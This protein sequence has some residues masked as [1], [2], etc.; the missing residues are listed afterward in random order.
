[1]PWPTLGIIGARYRWLLV[2]PC[3]TPT[4]LQKALVALAV[5]ATFAV[6]YFAHAEKLGKL[7]YYGVIPALLFNKYA[8]QTLRAS[9][10][11][12]K[13]ALR[14]RALQ[15]QMAAKMAAR[16]ADLEARLQAFFAAPDQ[17]TTR[18]M[19]R[20]AARLLSAARRPARLSG[21][22]AAGGQRH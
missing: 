22:Y 7:V 17:P 21:R 20:R 1:M 4:L 15:A 8:F 19:G 3:P 14:R 12:T 9:V 2:D 16:V 10:V 11:L 6:A 13:L 18:R 5:L